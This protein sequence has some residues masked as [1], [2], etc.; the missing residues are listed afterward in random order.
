[1]PFIDVILLS[2][3]PA[4]LIAVGLTGRYPRSRERERSRPV[5]PAALAAPP[6][7]P[8][9]APRVK[10]TV[11]RASYRLRAQRLA[12]VRSER[13]DPAVVEIGARAGRGL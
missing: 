12:I 11:A 4:L 5:A 13:E 7:G 2:L 8:L 9:V 1:M 6:T 3:L 10:P